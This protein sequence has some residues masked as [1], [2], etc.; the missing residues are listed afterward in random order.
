MM[1]PPPPK[2][3]APQEAH[4]PSAMMPPSPQQM[5]G[6]FRPSFHVPHNAQALVA[7]VAMN[8][9][10]GAPVTR[11]SL[12][13]VASLLGAPPQLVHQLT[14]GLAPPPE[15]VQAIMLKAPLP[16]RPRPL[17]PQRTPEQQQADAREQRAL[18][19]QAVDVALFVATRARNLAAAEVA[20]AGA[21][22]EDVGFLFLL[23]FFFC[24]K[25]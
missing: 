2:N 13:C 18:R 14:L 10:K 4:H 20:A 16:P 6:G 7:N 24:E 21:S 3:F 17:A 5:N 9:T 8:F 22:Y 23:V 11:D 1:Y 15:L 12:C 19:L 25:K